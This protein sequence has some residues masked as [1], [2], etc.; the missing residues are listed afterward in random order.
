MEAITE[1]NDA[2]AD[3]DFHEVDSHIF[4]FSIISNLTLKIQDNE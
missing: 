3:V 4:T 1:S 2:Y